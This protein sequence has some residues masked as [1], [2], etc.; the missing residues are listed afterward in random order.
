[1]LK[2]KYE[3]LKATA[4]S[5]LAAA[6]SAFQI[7]TLTLTPAQQLRKEQAAWNAEVDRKKALKRG[8]RAHKGSGG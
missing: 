4:S 6:G 1:M 3:R 7:R 5:M 8:N 2:G